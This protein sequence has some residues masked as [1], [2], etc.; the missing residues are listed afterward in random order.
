MLFTNIF[1]YSSILPSTILFISLNKASNDLALTNITSSQFNSTNPL[2][3]IIIL[4]IKNMKKKSTKRN[5]FEWAL[6]IGVPL[7]IYLAGWHT[8]V[9][10]TI[11]RLVLSTGV[12]QPKILPASEQQQADYNFVLKSFDEEFTSLENFKGKTIIINFWA[13]WCPPCIAEM[14]ALQNLYGKVGRSKVEFIMINLDDD[15]QKAKDFLASKKYTFP[16]YRIA[17]SFPTIYQSSTI[18][19]TFV[20]SPEGKIVVKVKGMADYNNDDFI[21][22]LLKLS[23]A[24]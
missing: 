20:I 7:V 15:I 4:L 16:N 13:S 5:I 17:G 1:Y 12:I 9:I 11:Q 19:T 18:P 2:T 23:A 3:R 8:E 24:N 21:D 14:P 6:L 22:E 10:G